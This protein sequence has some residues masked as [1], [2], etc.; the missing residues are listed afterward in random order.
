MIKLVNLSK[1]IKSSRQCSRCKGTFI[2]ELLTITSLNE[3][4]CSKC[5]NKR[6]KGKNYDLSIDTHSIAIDTDPSS[7]D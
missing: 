3:M 2:R 1:N 6:K 4:L 7:I 5:F